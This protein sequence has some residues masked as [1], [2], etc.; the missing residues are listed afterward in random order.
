MDQRRLL[1]EQIKITYHTLRP[2]EQRVA[3]L[4]LQDPNAFKSMS[5]MEIA[6]GSNV[7]EATISR[8]CKAVGL[9]GLRQLRK[10]IGE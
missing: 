9:K 5:P 2:S 4:L 6:V 3:D 7:S 8:V 10:Q 1:I